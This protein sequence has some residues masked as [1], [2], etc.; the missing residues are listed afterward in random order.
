MWMMK[1]KGALRSIFMW[2]KR[3]RRLLLVRVKL[4]RRF[5]MIIPV[6]LFVL[7][8]T[9]MEV[10]NWLEMW[11][12]VAAKL[13]GYKLACALA[14]SMSELM[15]SVRVLKRVRLVEVETPEADILIDLW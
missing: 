14:Q 11:K 1:K 5:P 3:R 10:R 4:N 8:E 2:I 6:S 7:H 12:P 15:E 9:V 13:S